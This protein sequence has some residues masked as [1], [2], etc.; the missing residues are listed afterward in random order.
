MQF[1]LKKK[2]APKFSGASLKDKNR[3]F[4]VGFALG[5]ESSLVEEF[6]NS[7][8]GLHLKG[9]VAAGYPAVAVSAVGDFFEVLG[10]LLV[11][12]VELLEIFDFGVLVLSSDELEGQTRTL[13]K[14]VCRIAK[15]KNEHREYHGR[16]IES[17]S[18]SF[19]VVTNAADYNAAETKGL[20]SDKELLSC[21]SNVSYSNGEELFV[22]KNILVLDG[23]ETLKSVK[24]CTEKQSYRSLGNPL[25]T[26]GSSLEDLALSRIG[27]FDNAVSLEIAGG[28][29]ELCAAQNGFND[30]CGNG[31]VLKCAD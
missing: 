23:K 1:Q 7:V 25:L 27:N 3:L 12:S 11:I 17:L 8:T 14:L 4:S 9:E 16:K 22:V 20:S 28:G 26:A 29:S 5:K 13:G 2:E 21:E 15:G 31:L 10:N 19:H 6:A 30:L 24:V 18:H